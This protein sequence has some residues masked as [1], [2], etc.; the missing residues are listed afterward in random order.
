MAAFDAIYNVEMQQIDDDSRRRVLN[1]D[2]AAAAADNDLPV[3]VNSESDSTFVPFG[4]DDDDDDDDNN[5]SGNQND[6]VAM[7]LRQASSSSRHQDAAASADDGS[8]LDD[9]DGEEMMPRFVRMQ[10]RNNN[11]QGGGGGGRIIGD[12]D[13]DES[14]ATCPL[15]WEEQPYIEDTS[16]RTAM[17]ERMND[18][19]RIIFRFE[20]MM[21][22]H[23][24]D[25][26][27]FRG[28]LELRKMY[29]ENDLE[30]YSADG[31]FQRWTLEML[32]R[33]YSP[34]NGHRFDIVR[35]L[36]AE[37]TDMR[38]QKRWIMD[39]AMFVAHPET[40]ERIFN[41]RAVET[42]VRLARE[43]SRVLTQKSLELQKR[44]VTTQTDANLVLQ[45]INSA[46]NTDSRK[47]KRRT[48]NTS[49]NMYELGGL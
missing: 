10:P 4:G 28:M 7:I 29:I 15:C 38:R 40:G 1:D 13:G 42:S 45:A 33:H 34:L 31:R 18:F 14:V 48:G 2:D 44:A 24:N 19:R 26:V 5:N 16:M 23:Q 6:E 25:E 43:Y 41:I 21:A 37:L 36:D 8:D 39:H 20:R 47:R 30:R 9:D 22:G 35:E 11:N 46:S 17:S 12:D 3:A 49:A 32:R 27:I